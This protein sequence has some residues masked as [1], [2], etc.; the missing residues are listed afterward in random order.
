MGVNSAQPLFLQWRLDSCFEAE[1]QGFSFRTKIEGK[2]AHP[3]A[4]E[5]SWLLTSDW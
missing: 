2:A 4:V 5:I 3:D 1:L